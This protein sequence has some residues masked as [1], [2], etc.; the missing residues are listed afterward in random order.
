MAL[1]AGD[2]LVTRGKL[3]DDSLAQSTAKGDGGDR[4]RAVNEGKAQSTNGGKMHGGLKVRSIC[5]Q[6]G[7]D[8]ISIL[9][10]S[11]RLGADAL[12]GQNRAIYNCGSVL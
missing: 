1:T 6:D 4:I 12:G 11:L 3:V 10:D 5:N 8:R 9:Q 7:A 2:Q